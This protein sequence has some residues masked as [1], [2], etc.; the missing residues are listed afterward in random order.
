MKVKIKRELVLYY[1][2]M[3]DGCV[4]VFFQYFSRDVNNIWNWE[5]V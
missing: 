4:R 1:G 5:G 3:M 2:L